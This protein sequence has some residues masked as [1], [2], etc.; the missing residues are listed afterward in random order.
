MIGGYYTSFT[1]YMC[2]ET[3]VSEVDVNLIVI[4]ENHCQYDSTAWCSTHKDYGHKRRRARTFHFLIGIF[5]T[6]K[7][8][9]SISAGTDKIL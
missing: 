9:S 5:A 7:E 1:I 2:S 4:N 6:E 8:P 3:V